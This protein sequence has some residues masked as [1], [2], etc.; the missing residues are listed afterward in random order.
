[1]YDIIKGIVNFWGM[2]ENS[3]LNFLR[4]YDFLKVGWDLDEGGF[5]FFVE[6]D[7]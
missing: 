3:N 6:K 2:F 1:M 4:F 5:V 7:L